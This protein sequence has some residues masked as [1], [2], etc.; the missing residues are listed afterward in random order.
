[1]KVE[2]LVPVNRTIDATLHCLLVLRRMLMSRFI[3][4]YVLGRLEVYV[5]ELCQLYLDPLVDAPF[6]LPAR[7]GN[8]HS[9][10]TK[11]PPDK[12]VRG[13]R[14]PECSQIRGHVF[15]VMF[16]ALLYSKSIHLCRDFS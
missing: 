6:L 4:Y 13:W 8:I 9:T 14:S 7:R 11:L 3:V 16:A 1:M 12:M 10:K 15:A 2:R 5:C